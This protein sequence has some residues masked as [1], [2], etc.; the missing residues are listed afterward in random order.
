[1]TECK[2][3]RCKKAVGS[4]DTDEYTY[5]D[6]TFCSP[7]CDLKYDLLKADARE[8][9]RADKGQAGEPERYF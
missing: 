6:S 1:M 9:R 8:A 7:M 5:R 2:Y 4:V 3:P